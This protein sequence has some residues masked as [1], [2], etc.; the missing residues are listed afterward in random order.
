MI[1]CGKEIIDYG[2]THQT[3]KARDAQDA[4]MAGDQP[5]FS[6]RALPDNLEITQGER[7]YSRS[8]SFPATSQV[9]AWSIWCSSN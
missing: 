2:G 7:V 3:S 9:P 1:M 5:G 4:D 6:D 8:F